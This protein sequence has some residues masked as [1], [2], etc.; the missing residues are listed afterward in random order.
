MFRQHFDQREETAP[1]CGSKRHLHLFPTAVLRGRNLYWF[2]QM[3]SGLTAGIKHRSIFLFFSELHHHL[4]LHHHMTQTQQHPHVKALKDYSTT[5]K[6]NLYQMFGQRFL[7][8][9]KLTPKHVTWQLQV[10]IRRFSTD[11]QRTINLKHTQ[12]VVPF[13]QSQAW[14]SGGLHQRKRRTHWHR[15]TNRLQRRRREEKRSR[16]FILQPQQSPWW[17]ASTFSFSYEHIITVF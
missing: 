5:S 17:P 7:K 4:H 9:H 10:E 16:C 11:L 15:H 12:R 13:S 6:I 8:R 2:L 3:I 1:P 14:R